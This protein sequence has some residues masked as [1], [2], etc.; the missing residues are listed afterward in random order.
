MGDLVLS[1]QILPLSQPTHP[2]FTTSLFHSLALTRTFPGR[3]VVVGG[4]LGGSGNLA[5][6]ELLGW[7]QSWSPPPAAACLTT[8]DSQNSQRKEGW[9]WWARKP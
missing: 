2:L 7:R 8:R 1:S 9:G 3:C 4:L 5:L 6:Q